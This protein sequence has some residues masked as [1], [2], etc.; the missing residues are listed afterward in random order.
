VNRGV[1]TPTSHR[2]EYPETN[3]QSVKIFQKMTYD[4]RMSEKDAS[5][6]EI[7]SVLLAMKTIAVVG[8]STKP[9]RPSHWIA[10]YLEQAGFTVW[11]VNPVA[12]STSAFEVYASLAACPASPDVVDV[13]R[14][15]PQ[16]PGIV[17]AAIAAQA[18]A[19]WMQPG[20]ENPDAAETARAAGLDVVMGPCIY[21]EHRRLMGKPVPENE[22]GP[23]NKR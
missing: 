12:E 14:A 1:E 15:P 22:H 21:R 3:A 13:F 4:G 5:F 19:I 2:Q 16:V 10:D 9:A 11:R 23:P 8:W 18:A 20:T 7:D 6:P 17:D